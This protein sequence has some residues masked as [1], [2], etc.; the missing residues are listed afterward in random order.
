M[1]VMESLRTPSEMAGA[2]VPIE[3]KQAHDTQ[4]GVAFSF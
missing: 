3:L 4:T 1:A 2:R